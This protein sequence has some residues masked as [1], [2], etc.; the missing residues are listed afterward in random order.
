MSNAKTKTLQKLIAAATERNFASAKPFVDF[1][2]AGS[3]EDAIQ[4]L[5]VDCAF[6]GDA[7]IK[8]MVRDIGAH[9]VE[10]ARELVPVHGSSEHDI[11]GWLPISELQT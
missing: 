10:V 9:R 1:D 4:N 11:V 3:A 2:G 7:E 5:L 8:A 6:S